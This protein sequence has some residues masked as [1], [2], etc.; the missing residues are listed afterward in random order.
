MFRKL[1]TTLRSFSSS[2][3]KKTRAYP[4]GPVLNL[5]YIKQNQ[6]VIARSK[7]KLK[8]FLSCHKDRHSDLTTFV[9]LLFDFDHAVRTLNRIDGQAKKSVEQI[10]RRLFPDFHLVLQE[11]KNDKLTLFLKERFLPS[12]RAIFQDLAHHYGFHPELVETN[13]GLLLDDDYMDFIKQG[14]L[15]LDLGEDGHGP[16]P[17]IIAA[18]MMKE[19]EIEGRIGSALALYQSL[20]ERCDYYCP[21][22]V[23]YL[24]RFHLL[25][26]FPSTYPL[27]AT[28]FCNPS[29]LANHLLFHGTTLRQIAVICKNHANPL[30]AHSLAEWKE[31]EN[32]HYLSKGK[33][34][35]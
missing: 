27:S 23:N 17:H 16:L 28:L 13:D 18:F 31:K 9:D 29:S 12:L 34:L 32:K 35:I 30:A 4:A 7:Q 10:D 25:L 22:R 33:V 11:G 1:P 5:D 3:I 6:N 21:D 15:V 24:Y 19:L 20:T 14:K 26:D 2:L 8:I